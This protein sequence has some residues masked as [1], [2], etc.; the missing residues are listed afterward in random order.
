M[1]DFPG[2][3]LVIFPLWEG[4]LVIIPLVLVELVKLVV[5]FVVIFPFCVWS[6]LGVDYIVFD[7]IITM[8]K[9]IRKIV[10]RVRTPQRAIKIGF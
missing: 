10:A 4:M 7:G 2:C 3:I 5:G 9:M 1:G 6:V 8:K